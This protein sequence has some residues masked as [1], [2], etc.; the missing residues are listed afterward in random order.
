MEKKRSEPKI[1]PRKAE[2]GAKRNCKFKRLA[3]ALPKF[4][5][6]KTALRLGL[7][8]PCLQDSQNFDSDCQ[9]VRF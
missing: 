5:P 1:L 4:S 8:G 2:K 9:T 7:K 3:Q 6:R